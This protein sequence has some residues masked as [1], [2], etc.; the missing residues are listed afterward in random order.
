M[1][2]FANALFNN[3]SGSTGIAG[4]DF[5]AIGPD[6]FTFDPAASMPVSPSLFA[7]D[8]S[9]PSGAGAPSGV[10]LGAS[11]M[12]ATTAGTQQ[13]QANLAMAAAAAAYQQQQQSSSSGTSSYGLP[14]AFL[15]QQQSNQN[16]QSLYPPQAPRPQEQS[17][18][19]SSDEEY[20]Q[21]ALR[22]HQDMYES[23]VQY[24]LAQGSLPARELGTQYRE[25]Q[26]SKSSQLLSRQNSQDQMQKA[27]LTEQHR[28]RQAQQ[29]TA[30]STSSKRKRDSPPTRSPPLSL[31]QRRRQKQKAIAA[32]AVAAKDAQDKADAAAAATAAANAAAAA[33]ATA[34]SPPSLPRLPVHDS[35]SE[36]RNEENHDAGFDLR[37]ALLK[38]MFR[39]NAQL[40]LGPVNASCSLTI[41]DLSLPDDPIVYCSDAFCKLTGYDRKD[42]MN[43]NCRFLQS[44]DGY[45]EKGAQRLHTDQTA[46]AHLKRNLEKRRESQVS[47]LNYKKGGAPFINLVTVVP[48]DLYDVGHMTHL[49]GFQIDLVRHPGAVLRQMENGSYVVD[50]TNVIS[51]DSVNFST[52]EAS[53][54]ELVQRKEEAKVVAKLLSS[55]Q[56]G[57]SKA[58][59]DEDMVAK[60]I[61]N[62]SNDLIWALSAGLDIV[63]MSPSCRSILG[64]NP[65]DLI[66]T[67]LSNIL[68]PADAVQVF[69]DIKDVIRS[70]PRDETTDDEKSSSSGNASTGPP[71]GPGRGKVFDQ[72]DVTRFPLRM[73]T[74]SNT[75]R[76]ID[77]MGHVHRDNARSR[78]SLILAGRPRNIYHVSSEFLP[79]GESSS[80][81]RWYRVSKEGIVLYV[82]DSLDAAGNRETPWIGKSIQDGVISEHK[83]AFFEALQST[84]PVVLRH[85]IHP[86]FAGVPS[87]DVISKFFSPLRAPGATGERTQDATSR[88]IHTVQAPSGSL[89]QTN[90]VYPCPEG[91]TD[92]HGA[93][94]SSIFSEFLS[95]QNSA[96]M[97]ELRQMQMLNKR[98]KNEINRLRSNS[99]SGKGK[100]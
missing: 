40:E 69:R 85:S 20:R 46:V 78:K 81:G 34:S 99:A 28:Q 30:P 73:K 89:M 71:Q 19:S 31:Q 49:V 25:Q 14:P 41:A 84:Q 35:L 39:P 67:S 100:K 61:L 47:F 13:G 21:A 79:P 8:P 53:T 33:F 66:G 10:S 86:G 72:G 18:L 16:E 15:Q 80:T 23:L 38:V 82:V 70:F 11:M 32:A 24:A 4:L 55:S 48:I 26:E 92:P 87:G 98:L 93:F 91:A 12:D 43:R 56:E 62:N 76:W 17:D 74:A 37:K 96:W 44:P 59:W 50:Y 36:E 95:D 22:R 60:T 83:A 65:D 63:Y 2:D 42:V 3:G 7:T 29:P 64:Y 6:A 77:N 58:T 45:L 97:V 9:V 5:G 90:V 57:G 52:T 54:A 51:P 27:R 94:H 68:H 75:Y 88:W 1:T